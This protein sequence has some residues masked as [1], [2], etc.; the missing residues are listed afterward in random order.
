MFHFNK[1]F[2]SLIS[3]ASRNFCK[4]GLCYLI[5]NIFVGHVCDILFLILTIIKRKG[6]Y[7]FNGE[8]QSKGRRK[9]IGTDKNVSN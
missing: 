9:R 4:E 6:H 2:E 7:F 3:E 8:I 5:L 1:D